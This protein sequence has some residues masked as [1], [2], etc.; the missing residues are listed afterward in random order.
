V[1]NFVK[2]WLAFQDYASAEE[3]SS[4]EVILFMAIFR[5]FN[6]HRWPDGALGITN[7]QLLNHTTFNTTKR[8]DVLR[9]TREKLAER[10]LITYTKG[11]V[12]KSRATYAINWSMLLDDAPET[13]PETAPKDAPENGDDLGVVS[14]GYIIENKNENVNSVPDPD[15]EEHT[16]DDSQLSFNRARA[17][18]SAGYQPF[19]PSNPSHNDNGWRY[20]DRARY[21]IARRITDYAAELMKPGVCVTMDGTV[22]RDNDA[23][24]VLVKAMRVGMSPTYLMIS[25]DDYDEVWAWLCHIKLAAV[26][27][28]DAPQEWFDMQEDFRSA[29]RDLA[30]DG[31]G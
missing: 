10:G 3:L 28:G 7:N 9:E 27:A 20:S 17:E 25:M 16:Q 29:L 11:V 5:C 23:M 4:N 15:D 22:L 1:I 14:G 13:A 26:D 6:D 18:K 31:G 21:A 30:M 19:D 24:D 8:D 12:Y 2:A